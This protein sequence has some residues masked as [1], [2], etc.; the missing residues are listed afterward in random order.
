MVTTSLMRRTQRSISSLES[1]MMYFIC[2]LV[3]LPLA[4]TSNTSSVVQYG[5][6]RAALPRK[7]TSTLPAPVIRSHPVLSV[8]VERGC[9]SGVASGGGVS[10]Q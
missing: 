5:V 9:P 4:C 6:K 2:I 8:H 10:R 1:S 7:E 3:L